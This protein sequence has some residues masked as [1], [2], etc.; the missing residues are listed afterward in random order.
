MAQD[1]EGALDNMATPGNMEAVKGKHKDMD[2]VVDS[3]EGDKSNLA[4]LN[5]PCISFV[6]L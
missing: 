4:L 3:T 5:A 6:P 1:M 2:K